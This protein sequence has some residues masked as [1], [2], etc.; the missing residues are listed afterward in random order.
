M[1]HITTELSTD[2]LNFVKASLGTRIQDAEEVTKKVLTAVQGLAMQLDDKEA[3]ESLLAIKSEVAMPSEVLPMLQDVLEHLDSQDQ[4]SQLIA[5]LYTVLQFEDRTRQ[6]MEGLI[7]TMN[8]WA[9]V[10]SDDSISEEDMASGLMQ[11]VVSM[12]QQAILAKYFPD[13]IQV[14]EVSDEVELF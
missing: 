8:M 10:R 6:K 13:H 4:L 9:E 1:S 14:E 11:H 7:G 3:F 12:D 2:W 5:P